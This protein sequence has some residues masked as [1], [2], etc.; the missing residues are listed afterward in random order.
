MKTMIT[1]LIACL[2]CGAAFAQDQRG[3]PREWLRA[4]KVRIQ[5]IMQAAEN[6]QAAG[7]EQEANRLRELARQ[8][9]EELEAKV[10]QAEQQGDREQVKREQVKREPSGERPRGDLARLQAQIEELRGV[11]RKL[12]ERIERLEG[13]CREC[14]KGQESPAQ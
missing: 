11:V 5:K 2:C 3:E 14:R 12:A 13:A 10:R 8:Q 1:I 7:M 4:E 6:L 9:A